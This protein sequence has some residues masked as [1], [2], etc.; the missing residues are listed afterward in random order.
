VPAP[1]GDHDPAREKWVVADDL[2]VVDV[3][4]E[5]R[6]TGVRTREIVGGSSLEAIAR[7]GGRFAPDRE[8]PSL[9]WILLHVLQEYARHIGHLDVA[10]ELLD[11]AV[12]E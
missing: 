5:L 8:A 11:G 3:V 4:S 1:W 6:A 10:R 9:G 2:S 7:K 12:G